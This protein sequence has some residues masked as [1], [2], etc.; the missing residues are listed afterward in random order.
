M[1]LT[2][3]GKTISVPLE[4]KMDPRVKTS[5]ADLERQFQ[6]ASRLAAGVGEFSAAAMRAD[7][8]QKQ[9]AARRKKRREMR[10][11]RRRWRIW[12]RKLAQRREREG[13]ANLEVLVSLFREMTDDVATSVSCHGHA[14]GNCGERGCGAF[15]R[16]GGG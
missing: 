5:A 13:A 4:I 16:C 2:A 10:R 6:L 1:K 9:I 15:G 11:L 8:L 14:D 12:R 7:D 3:A